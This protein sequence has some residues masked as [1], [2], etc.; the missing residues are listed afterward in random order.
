MNRSVGRAR[1]FL[2]AACT[3]LALA[4]LTGGCDGDGGATTPTA[5]TNRAPHAT[6]VIPSVTLTAGD[7]ATLN[8]ASYF[9]DQDNGPLTFTAVSSNADTV[10]VSVSG[11][12]LT[13]NPR[14]EGNTTVTATAHDPGGLSAAQ[15]FGVTVEHL[16]EVSFTR[17]LLEVREGESAPVVIHYQVAG[18]AAART[19]QLS[20]LP[21]TASREDF[22]LEGGPLELPPGEGV[23]G[24][25]ALR[26]TART[27][28]L[29]AEGDETVTIRFIPDRDVNA[30]LGAALEVVIEEAG[31]LPCPGI[32]IEALLPRPSTELDRHVTTTLMIERS[33]AAIGT[34]LDLVRP[35]RHIY[36][37]SASPV[38]T[39][40]VSR[41]R[42]QDT[43]GALRHELDV[44]WSEE[45]SEISVG[46]V[47]GQC[48]GDPVAHCFEDGCEL[49]TDGGGA[50]NRA[51]RAVGR[52]A[53]QTLT[54][55]GSARTLDVSGNFEDPDGD[56]LAYR[57]SSSRS[58]VVRVSVADSDVILIPVA[59]GTAAVT[60][61]ATDPGGLSASQRFEVTVETEPVT[62]GGGCTIEN[63]GTFTGTTPIT[64]SG[65]LGHDCVSP[66]F[67]GE[68]ARYYSFRLLES[69]EIQIDLASSAFDP[70][71]A[72]RRGAD[73]SGGPIDFDDNGGPGL[74]SRLI[75]E[76]S[77][78]T[79]TIEATSA[80]PDIAVTGAFTLT[81][82]R[83]GRR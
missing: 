12:A 66:N 60:V 52:I 11:S 75:V 64:R 35:Y 2:R 69:A 54:E 17:N 31:A 77:P 3:C 13:L 82:A 58:S 41:W 46:F 68:L 44:E 20:A 30:E 70:W 6:V 10:S 72:L 76:L 15:T 32:R 49:T 63:L 74:N 9:S 4:A 61:T 34:S 79:Y 51:P 29:F 80:A 42:T 7:A 14:H 28:G 65:T 21:G 71:V 45:T 55:D 56:I 39:M 50:E 33:R 59:A 40:R 23:S 57:V 36:R 67:T 73:I 81:V 5:P 47:G 24:Q 48:S 78:G 27:D 25:F 8:L 53:A 83:E 37:G 62:G 1:H 22:E 16:V 26:L 19:V 18:L 43:G 38:R